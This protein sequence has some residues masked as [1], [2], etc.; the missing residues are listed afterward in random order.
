MRI[1]IALNFTDEIKNNLYEQVLYLKKQSAKGNF[2]RK[3]NLHLTLAFLGEVREK[4][5]E[6]LK[7]IMNQFEVSEFLIEF[8]DMGAFRNGDELLPYIGIVPNIKLLVLQQN[9][10]EVLKA[11]GFTPDEKKFTPHITLGRKVVMKSNAEFY[12]NDRL[13]EKEIVSNTISIMKSER[14]NGI[15]TYTEIYKREI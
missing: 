15:L 10:I 6:T 2:T 5:L 9:L 1:F 12:G 14:I 7:K 8:S 13:Y 4:Q 3:E 11:S